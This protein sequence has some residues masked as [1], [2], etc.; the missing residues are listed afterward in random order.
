MALRNHL[1]Q[2][3]DAIIG[4]IY[5]TI[6][7]DRAIRFSR[8]PDS[9]LL[10]RFPITNTLHQSGRSAADPGANTRDTYHFSEQ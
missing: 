1:L 6:L 5:A 8:S 3:F 4:H 7:N 2:A 9:Y 10:P